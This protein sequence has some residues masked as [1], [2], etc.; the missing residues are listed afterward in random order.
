MAQRHRCDRCN[1]TM[2]PHAHYVV[3]IDVFADPSMPELSGE[4]LEEMDFDE[5]F[6]KLLEQMK[7]MSEQELQDQVHRR[8]EFTLCPRCQRE[9]LVNPLGRPRAEGPATN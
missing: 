1:V 9:Y 5:T 4:D 7:Q 6:R 3:R 2:P 8:F